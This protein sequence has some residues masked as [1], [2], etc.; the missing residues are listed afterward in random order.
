MAA[1][2]QQQQERKFDAVRQPRRKRMGFEM[3]DRDQ[4]LSRG[5]RQRLGRRQPHHHAAD[6]PRPSRGRHR[7]DLSER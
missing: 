2:D 5:Q 1:G 4:R 6:Q 3:I 7:V